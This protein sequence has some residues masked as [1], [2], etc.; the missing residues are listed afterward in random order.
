[1]FSQFIM[2][3]AGKFSSP[4]ASSP[5]LFLSSEWRSKIIIT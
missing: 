1:M 2:N 3:G 4:S 5:V